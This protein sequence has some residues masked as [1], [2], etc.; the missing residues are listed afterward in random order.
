MVHLRPIKLHPG[1]SME[2]YA[3][4]LATL[5]PGFSGADIANLCN[6]AAIIAARKNQKTVE[7]EDFELAS[8]RV[9]AGLEKKKTMTPEEVRIVA[10]HESGHAVVS[11]FLE[12]G[13]PLLKLTIVPRARGSLGFAQYLPSDT[14]LETRDELLD[15]I[16][17]ILGGRLAE[18]VFFNKLT[19]GAYDDLKKVYETAHNI[20]TK[21]G[22][23][24][25]IGYLG[26][27][28]Q[29]HGKS[30][31]EE[32]NKLIDQEIKKIVDECTARARA[33]VIEHKHHIEN[34]SKLLLEKETLDLHAIVSVLGE[35]PFKAKENFRAY[36]EIKKQE[37]IEKGEKG[38]SGKEATSTA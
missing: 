22:M 26:Y 15:R 35:R 36:L 23:S 33:L 32:T 2:E 25:T 17:C 5:T 3:K 34:L 20:V 13:A 7:P 29:E 10:V 4:R 21:F 38:T 12:G 30:Y 6:E 31:S 28:E 14:H 8:E 27:N 19:T 24:E 11:W 37:E 1:K 9:M 18:E 16:C